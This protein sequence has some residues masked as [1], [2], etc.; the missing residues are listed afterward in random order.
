MLI[1]VGVGG[2]HLLDDLEVFCILF[3]D[4]GPSH[5]PQGILTAEEADQKPTYTELSAPYHGVQ[6][7]CM[8]EIHSGK[9]KHNKTTL[10]TRQ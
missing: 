4:V 2:G 8:T 10:C 6:L 1:L 9:D 3:H 7:I 5:S